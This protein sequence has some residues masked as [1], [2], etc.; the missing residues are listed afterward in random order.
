[1]A[2]VRAALH[3]HLR[4]SSKLKKGCFNKIFGL[5]N[6]R[7]G[8]NGIFSLVDFDDKRYKYLIGLQGYDRNYIG[9]DRRAIKAYGVVCVHGEEV[10]TKQG[11]LLVIGLGYNTHLKHNRTIKDTVKETRDYNSEATIILDHP[12][13]WKGVG[14]YVKKHLEVLYEIDAIEGFNAEA[15]GAN[16]KALDFYLEIK[17]DYPHLGFFSTSDGHSVLYE[18]CRSWTEIDKLDY[19]SPDRFS[20]TLRTAVQNTD[21]NTVS[22]KSK[23]RGLVGAI[24]HTLGL[25]LILGIAPK[26]GLE[27]YFNKGIER[28]DDN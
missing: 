22:R 8:S 15:V 23:V 2:K 25:I 7:L 17:K 4:T 10:P 27:N 11:H 14:E 28:P 21:E 26:I 5:A 3:E 13:G 1:M 6:K 9:E 19:S 20:K 16:K 18:F 24:G 12:F